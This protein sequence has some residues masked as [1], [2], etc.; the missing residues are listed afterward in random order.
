ML[1]VRR[2]ETTT[3]ILLFLFQAFLIDRD[4]TAIPLRKI[5]RL[6]E[7]FDK[8]ESAIRMGLSR[9]VKSGLLM[10][11]KRNGEVYYGLTPLTISGFQDWRTTFERFRARIPRQLEPWNDVWTIAYIDERN[12]IEPLLQECSFGQ[13]GRNT[14]V[15]PFNIPYSL[16]KEFEEKSPGI[17]IFHSQRIAGLTNPMI[18]KKVWSLDDLTLNY[19][20]YVRNLEK[21]YTQLHNEAEP[22]C[23]GLPFLHRFGLELFELIQTDPQ[24]PKTLLPE[25]WQGL[26][27]IQKF[28]TYRSEL[29]RSAESFIFNILN[30]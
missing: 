4:I 30:Q 15:S 23:T 13:L 11:E 12:N 7:P 27:A 6:M 17:T 9:E 24:L 25:D 26:I 19:D 21:A 18:A 2:V 5:F 28:N 3:G 10:N 8:S 1:S 29:I 14:W 20:E 16:L 22:D